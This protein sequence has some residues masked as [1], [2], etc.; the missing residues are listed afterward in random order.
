MKQEAKVCETIAADFDQETLTGESSDHAVNE[1]A[2]KAWR[3]KS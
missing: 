2:A 3:L 1:Q